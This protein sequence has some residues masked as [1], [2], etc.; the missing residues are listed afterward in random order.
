MSGIKNI[1]QA[2][3]CVT[4]LPYSFTRRELSGN[5]ITRANL[6][7]ARER[8]P[9]I[10]LLKEEYY[11]VGKRL[12]LATPAALHGLDINLLLLQK[13][14]I[15]LADKGKLDKEALESRGFRV[16][17]FGRQ[18]YFGLHLL[19][20]AQPSD[21]AIFDA[22][23]WGRPG[24]LGLAEN[25]RLVEHFLRSFDIIIENAHLIATREEA[26]TLHSLIQFSLE[27]KDY[28]STR[29]IMIS[30]Y[31]Y[32]CVF[33]FGQGEY[34]ISKHLLN[35]D[36]SRGGWPKLIKFPTVGAAIVIANLPT[37][38]EA[39]G[40][41]RYPEL[42]K[43]LLLATPRAFFALSRSEKLLKH[44]A[45]HLRKTDKIDADA[46]QNC[47]VRQESGYSPLR[48]LTDN[49]MNNRFVGLFLNT[50]EEFRDY[51][52]AVEELRYSRDP[53]FNPLL[54]VYG[55]K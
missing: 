18:G 24:S 15:G 12:V 41:F 3:R 23:Y 28:A 7:A 26:H 11:E 37:L 40:I 10:N 47:Y 29:R 30:S 4:L 43:R 8:Y 31:P 19:D 27:D 17:T 44:L 14:Q 45:E 33:E 50:P 55:K 52:S 38:S 22:A 53:Q 48:F 42:L 6:E 25:P 32:N 36:F 34:F 21:A 49:R 9:D 39:T 16:I 54:F 1:F 13:L 2:G 51:Q 35:R 46:L 5:P 20:S